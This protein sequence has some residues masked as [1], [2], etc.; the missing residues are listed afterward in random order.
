MERK[1][2]VSLYILA[3]AITVGIFAIGFYV[4]GIF[5]DMNLQG[6]SSNID[7]VSKRV[8]SA[9]LL[10]LLEDSPSFCPVYLDEL[11]SID[12]ETDQLGQQLIYMED[13]KEI[14]DNELK[15]NY[16]ILETKSYLLSK[17][18]KEK[19][20]A[21]YSLALYFYSNIDCDKCKEQGEMLSSAKE[22]LEKNGVKLKVYSFDGEIGSPIAQALID[23][24]NV[25]EYPSIVL[26]ENIFSGFVSEG[27]IM[28]EINN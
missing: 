26:N 4:G 25:T 14:S 5:T 3:F 23:K 20:N 2:S 13:V 17:R 1:I 28:K 16:F 10:F 7:D 6:I 22:K 27:E 11:S 9:E 12:A 21:D 15:K 24:Y 18:I 8:S 19:C